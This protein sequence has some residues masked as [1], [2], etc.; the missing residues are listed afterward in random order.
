MRLKRRT[1]SGTRNGELRA[2]VLDA[3]RREP[4]ESPWSDLAIAAD[5]GCSEQ[6]VQQART[7]MKVPTS[8]LR[9]KLALTD[10]YLVG[11]GLAHCEACSR[12]YTLEDG[13]GV[14]YCPAGHG[15]IYLTSV[16]LDPV[17]TGID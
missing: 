3:L 8:R 16:R 12:W 13:E 11:P 10:D 7:A 2:R 15:R 1:R 14:R 9:R 4:P 5:L 17:E 6:N